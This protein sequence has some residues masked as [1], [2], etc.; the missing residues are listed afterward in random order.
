MGAGGNDR[1]VGRTVFARDAGQA[2][3]AAENLAKIL[4]L[5]SRN[6][7]TTFGLPELALDDRRQPDE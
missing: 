6:P 5:L 7:L 1:Y 3:E 4:G 2:F